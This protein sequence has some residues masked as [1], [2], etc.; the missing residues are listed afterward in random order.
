MKTY[1][2]PTALAYGPDAKRMIAESHAAPLAGRVDIA[3]TSAELIERRH[4]KITR[5][6]IPLREARAHPLF[7]SITTTRPNFGSQV[8]DHTNLMG[9]VNVTPDSFSDGGV[10]HKHETAIALARK[11]IADG[12]RILDIGGESTRP[13]AAD[14][15]IEDERSRIMSVIEVLAK[16]YCVSV[17]TRKAPIMQDAL[18]AGAAMIND[19]S[20]LQFDST[21]AVTLANAQTPVI[22]MHAQGNPRDM[23]KN[24]TYDDVALDVY[25]QLEALI[26]NVEAVGIKRHNIMVDPGIGFG[27]TFAHNLELMQQLTIFHGL[28]VGLLVGVSRKGFVGAITGEKIANQRLGGS[29]GGAVSAAMQGVQILR[30][31]DV[32]ETFTALQVLTATLNGDSAA[33]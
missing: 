2:R 21:S 8:L 4:Q 29:I 33:I 18:N 3:F 6:L 19:V 14:V 10:H 17:D 7:Q 15:S 11:M 25:D 1:L 12:A 23:Q 28:G 9:I 16:D 32:K 27:K 5:R 13:G 30:V 20:A 26:T 31:H 22:L 24:P